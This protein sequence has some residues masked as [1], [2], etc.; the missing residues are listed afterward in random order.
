MNNGR[1]ETPGV[2]TREFY[3]RDNDRLYIHHSQ[4]VSDLLDE[5]N[6][7]KGV[8]N[9]GFSQSRLWRRIG[10]IPCIVVEKVLREHG[11]NM[12][13]NSSEAEKYIRRF[14]ENNK[15]LMTVDKIG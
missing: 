11:V 2:T 12:L 7:A 15:K 6:F 10:S 4:D 9:N 14:L 13:E 1:P 3:D 8:G 5:N